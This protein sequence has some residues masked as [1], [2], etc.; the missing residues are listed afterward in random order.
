MKIMEHRVRALLY[1][2]VIVGVYA[3]ASTVF[4]QTAKSQ[5][6]GSYRGA[7]SGSFASNSVMGSVEFSV[8]NGVIT[9]TEPGRGA[10]TVDS[11]GAATFSGSLGVAR[12]TCKFTGAFRSSTR[13]QQSV[14]ATGSWSCTGSG[15]TGKGTWS[16]DRP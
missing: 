15:Q 8:A 7:Y 4:G 11:S 10:G 3:V 5:Y 6:D 2:A 9:V 1:V 12:V 13:A 14:H 16:A